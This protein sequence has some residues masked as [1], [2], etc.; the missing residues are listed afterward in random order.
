MFRNLDG[1]TISDEDILQ[2]LRRQGLFDAD[3][4]DLITWLQRFPYTKEIAERIKKL[5]S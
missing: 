5:I 3:V 2:I 4:L 1:D